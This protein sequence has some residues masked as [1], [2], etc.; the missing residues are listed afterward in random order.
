[1][2]DTHAS[3]RT[4]NRKNLIELARKRGYFNIGV[5]LFTVGSIFGVYYEQIFMFT[6]I[7]FRTGNIFWEPRTGLVYGPFSPIYGV[8]T[9]IIFLVCALWKNRKW[10]EYFLAGFFLSGIL[11]Y[12]MATGQEFFFGTRSWDYS[13]K[14]L[15][16]DGKTTIP[17]MLVW[18]ALFVLF[19]YVVLPFVAK[20]YKK[21][22]IKIS[23]I[24]CIILAV[25]LIYD[26]T[27]SFAAVYRQ[28]LRRHGVP[29]RNAIEQ[30]L[31]S[32]FTDEFLHT[33]YENA[34]PVERS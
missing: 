25:F 15:N 1:M 8:G 9:L 16:I 27:V 33:K 12:L 3:K 32:K 17:Y 7:Y 5:L 21:I 13:E 14:F 10:H 28:N 26:A 29:P 19:A 22:P 23:D 34:V 24:L 31:D 4:K 30:Y 18:G 2:A 20:L 6:T 11:E